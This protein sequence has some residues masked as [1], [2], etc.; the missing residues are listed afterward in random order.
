VLAC[1]VV[2]FYK[3]RGAGDISYSYSINAVTIA[4]RRNFY[5]T[6][7]TGHNAATAIAASAERSRLRDSSE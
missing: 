3:R 6:A 4:A 7:A 2:V 5:T 1:S